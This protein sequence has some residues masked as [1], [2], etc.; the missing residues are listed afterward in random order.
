MKIL[1]IITSL[2]ISL[3]SF[4]QKEASFNLKIEHDTVGIEDFLMVQFE[5]KNGKGGQF[6]APNFEGFELVNGPSSSSS[7]TIINGKVDQTITYSYILKPLKLGAYTIE[8][9][10]I[11]VEGK[12]LKSE[13]KKITVLEEYEAPETDEMQNYGMGIYPPRQE[14]QPKIQKK[15]YKTYK[16]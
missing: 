4:G 6:K 5:L 11:E 15:T 14:T 2:C 8:A 9:A 13:K 3:L 16:L 7:M 10:T 1:I 12:K